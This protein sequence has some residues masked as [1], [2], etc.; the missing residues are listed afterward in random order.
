MQLKPH[1]QDTLAAN[2]ANVRQR[3]ATAAQR[4]GRAA[5]SVRL[6]PIT[7][8][9]SSEVAGALVDLGCAALGESRP[10]ELWAKADALRDRPIEWHLVGPLQRNKVRRTIAV[11]DAIDSVDSLA[12]VEAIEAAAQ[13]AGRSPRILVEINISGQAARHGLTPDRLAE[14]IEW[15]AQPRG[16]RLAGLMGMAADVADPTLIARQ[17]ASLRQLREEWLPRLPAGAALDE[18]SMGMSGDYEIAIS[19]GA[20]L[21]RIGSA[22]FEGLVADEERP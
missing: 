9:V 8:Y 20:T 3:I 2:L 6:L 1:W 5:D 16:I 15:F 10:Q 19:Q 7:K 13:A 14:I 22:L 17:F 21:V 11:A 4:A 18:L 12:L